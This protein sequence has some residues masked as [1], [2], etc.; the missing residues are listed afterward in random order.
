MRIRQAIA[1]LLSCSIG[2]FA[3]GLTAVHPGYVMADI[4]PTGRNFLVGGIDLYSDGRLAVCNWGNP[5]EVWTVKGAEKGGADSVVAERFAF[6]MQQ[7]LGCKV[8]DDV[9]YV[10]QMGELTQ[11]ADTDGDGKADRYTRINDAFSTSESLLGYAYD[12]AYYGGFFYATLSADVK[13][14][15]MTANPS[16]KDRSVLIKMGRDNSLEYLASGF[17][18][19]NGIGVGFG[20][21]LF[22]TDNQGSWTPSSKVI[23]L[24]QGR[25]YGH[26]TEPA[27][28]FQSQPETWPMAWLPHGL[29][30]QT[31]GNIVFIREGLYKGQL[32]LAEEDERQKGKI[33]RISIQ[34]VDGVLQGAVLPFSGNIGSG[35]SRV[36]LGKGGVLYAGILGA[37]GGW[38]DLGSMRP[39]LRRFTPVNNAAA[40][41]FEILHVRSTGNSTIELEFTMPVGAGANEVG[42]YSVESWTFQPGEAYGSGNRVN[43]KT[44]SVQAATV[45]A[46]GKTVE[47]RIS[48]LLEKYLINIKLPGVKGPAGAGAWTSQTW[49]TLNKFG[50]GRIPEIAGCKDSKFL[51][52]DPEAT[53]NDPA[54]CATLKSPTAMA[55]P[56][57]DIRKSGFGRVRLD[58][59]PG[60]PY[61]A[62]LYD[63]RGKERGLWKGIGPDEI[64]VRP[65]ATG[66]ASSRY[67]GVHFLRIEAGSSSGT[68]MLAPTL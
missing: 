57:R 44:L 45:K 32:F 51:E 26:R 16:L 59:E 7:V 40:Q 64:D 30:S 22:G 12:V 42:S 9:L 52:F 49:F 5:G 18:N 38:S 1:L 43:L 11:V 50:P 4:Q 3:D 53:V 29:V 17:R 33:Y 58:V 65:S 60:Q 56:R 14:G 41:A 24:Q 46:D 20:N 15:G 21:K 27:N 2:S 55:P 34:E 19:P 63:I 13:R 39:G 8:V 6:G 61:E 48:G 66:P 36:V 62:R 37:T 23:H 25:F 54:G 68:L 47:L 67:P 10:M 35:V 31:P 28:R